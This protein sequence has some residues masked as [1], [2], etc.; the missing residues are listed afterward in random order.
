MSSKLSE[1]AILNFL[2]KFHDSSSLINLLVRHIA[3]GD[4][5]KTEFFEIPLSAGHRIFL[6]VLPPPPLDDRPT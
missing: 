2:G 1:K 4:T 5:S 6:T 3:K